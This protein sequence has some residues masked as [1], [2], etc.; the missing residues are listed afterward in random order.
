MVDTPLSWRKLCNFFPRIFALLLIL[1]TTGFIS[2]VTPASV[3]AASSRLENHGIESHPHP[4]YAYGHNETDRVS[5]NVTV[6]QLESGRDHG[7]DEGD[8]ESSLLGRDDLLESSLGAASLFPRVHALRVEESTKP[9]TYENAVSVIV[10]ESEA[11]IRLF[12]EGFGPNMVVKF[13]TDVRK[14]GS[15]CGKR[16]VNKLMRK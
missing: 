7:V 5:T 2:P 10:A 8:E 11:V 15:D 13:V 12:G 1:T 9:V 16:V 4:F 3:Q 6:I 14:A